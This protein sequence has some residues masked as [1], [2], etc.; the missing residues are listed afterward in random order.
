MP[1]P[2]NS[3]AVKPQ[4]LEDLTLRIQSAMPPQMIVPFGGGTKAEQFTLPKNFT[5]IS[6]QRLNNVIEY[7]PDDMTITVQAG[8]TLAK[9]ADVLAENNQRL[10]LDPPSMNAATVGG[11]LAANDSGPIR[12]ARGTARDLVIGIFLVK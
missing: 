11:V 3:L 1:Y 12:F 5:I 2:L 4:D 7:A 8:M 6:T 9:L 10:P